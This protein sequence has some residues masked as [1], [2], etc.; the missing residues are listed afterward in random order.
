MTIIN[1]SF[2]TSISF[3]AGAVKTLGEYLLSP[4]RNRPL[5]VTDKGIID[6]P[7][8]KDIIHYLREQPLSLSIYSDFTGNPV[9]S[10]VT[11]GVKVFKDNDCN[12]IIALGG[13]AALDVAKVIALMA[14]H[15]GD[16][17]DYIDGQATRQVD[18]PMPYIVAIP[19][20]A[21]TGSEVGRSSVISDDE[22]KTKKII[23]SPRLMPDQV[24]LDPEL[25][26]KL[27]AAVTAATGM[28]AL[29]HLIESYVVDAFNPLCDGIALEGLRLFSGSFLDC[30]YPPDNASRHLKARGEMLHAAMMGAI[31]FQKGLGLNHSLAHALSTVLDLHHGLAN[32]IMLPLTLEYNRGTVL[33]KFEVIA[34]CMGLEKN[35]SALIHWVKELQ[36][37]T[38]IPSTL[39]QLNMTSEVLEQLV[40]VAWNDPCHGWN[41]RIV[42]KEDIRRIFE[43]V[44]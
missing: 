16:L 22:T 7:F 38:A 4:E 23:F 44:M 29:T 8:T 5:L 18:Q 3:G 21:G 6:L 24:I 33:H 11:E 15:S 1:Y 41:P 20:T 26:L 30:Y 25:T 39:G 2:P 34:E 13:G 42:I 37:R 40:D 10:F 12:S 28:D 31:A 17:F 35:A 27:P 32:A 19:T 9:K 43:K 36:Q 14:Y